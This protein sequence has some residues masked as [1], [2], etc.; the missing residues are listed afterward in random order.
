MSTRGE[1]FRGTTR[2][3]GQLPPRGPRGPG[4]RLVGRPAASTGGLP[5]GKGLFGQRLRGDIRR[6]RPRGSHRPPV[7]RGQAAR[8]FVPINV[9]GRRLVV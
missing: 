7:A 8:L 6:I 9:L 2:L 1:E 5:I 4:A 3:R